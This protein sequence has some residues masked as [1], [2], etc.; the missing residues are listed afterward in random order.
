MV[1]THQASS[2]H[3]LFSVYLAAYLHNE[4]AMLTYHTCR[5]KHACKTPLPS[6]QVTI[7]AVATQLPTPAPIVLSSCFTLDIHTQLN[8]GLYSF[9]PLKTELPLMQLS[10][11]ISS[12]SPRSNVLGCASL[13]CHNVRQRLLP[14][15]CSLHHSRLVPAPQLT[16]NMKPPATRTA[17]NVNLGPNPRH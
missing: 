5:V 6:T 7:T 12:N 11:A 16:I 3:F 4:H 2:R 17:A 1:P 13:T 14:C 15:S 9:N 8:D 10:S